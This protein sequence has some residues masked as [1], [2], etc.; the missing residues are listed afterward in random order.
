MPSPNMG[1]S[2]QQVHKRL[3]AIDRKERL[4][5]RKIRKVEEIMESDVVYVDNELHTGIAAQTEIPMDELAIKFDQLKFAFK[6]IADLKYKIDTAPF[7]LKHEIGNDEKWIYYTGFD[8]IVEA[9][10]MSSNISVNLMLLDPEG[11]IQAFRTSVQDASSLRLLA[12]SAANK[13]AP[14]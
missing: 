11:I 9:L 7:G 2:S 14:T 4:E 6:K 5:K 3:D 10:R 13:R 8:F 12:Y 1:H